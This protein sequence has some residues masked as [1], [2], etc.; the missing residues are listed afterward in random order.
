MTGAIARSDLSKSSPI[1]KGMKSIRFPSQIHPTPPFIPDHFIDKLRKSGAWVCRN[2]LVEGAGLTALCPF[3]A[4][5]GGLAEDEKNLGGLLAKAY[6]NMVL[7]R[8]FAFTGSA[9]PFCLSEKPKEGHY[10]LH[11]PKVVDEFTPVLLL[12]HG[13]GGNLLYFPWAI[14][15]EHP[16]AILI[17]PSWQVHWTDGD[18]EDRRR[19]VH[20]A[21]KHA[22]Q[23][24]GFKL[25]KPWLVPLSQGG[26]MAFQ[27]AGAEPE[28]YKGLVG[29]S[30]AAESLADVKLVDPKFPV[31]LLHGGKDSRIE[32]EYVCDTVL[33]IQR[34][35][36][37]AQ[38]TLIEPANHF[39]LLSHPNR[40]GK[41]LSESIEEL[42]S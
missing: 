7:T 4:R 37:D 39:L 17:A 14:W 10:F 34:R 1:C 25:G 12:F 2:A 6:R 21:L 15:K 11:L 16:E 40:V 13:W 26:G 23:T 30:T 24:I 31:R 27:L 29:I 38:L 22:E 28:R 9:V 41:F 5:I 8:S 33:T 32:S 36:G 19:Y 18:F 3:L 20:T 42:D 35:G